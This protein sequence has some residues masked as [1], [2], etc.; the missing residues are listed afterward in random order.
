MEP[1]LETLKSELESARARL[2]KAEE[3]AASLQKLIGDETKMKEGILAMEK[4]REGLHTLIERYCS[5][6]EE[7]T[8]SRSAALGLAVDTSSCFT[9]EVPFDAGH[10]KQHKVIVANLLKLHDEKVCISCL[11]GMFTTSPADSTSNGLIC[12]NCG[13]WTCELCREVRG[14]TVPAED[15]D[16]NGEARHVENKMVNCLACKLGGA[17][18]DASK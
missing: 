2:S 1:S 7:G 12:V 13:T 11:L 8:A 5:S 4:A 6:P 16:E 18:P 3:A 15:L 10:L 17:L 14:I 9:C